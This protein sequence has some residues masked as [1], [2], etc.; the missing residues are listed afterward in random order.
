M[1][2]PEA[3]ALEHEGHRTFV[4]YRCL[5]RYLLW[6]FPKELVRDGKELSEKQVY[7]RVWR[8]CDRWGVKPRKPNQKRENSAAAERLVATRCLGTLNELERI[9]KSEGISEKSRQTGEC[10]AF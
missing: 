9:M 2:T 6:K 10:C 4:T 5:T 1:Y 8:W 3:T 7:D